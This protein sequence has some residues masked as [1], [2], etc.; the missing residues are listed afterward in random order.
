[1]NPIYGAPGA[2]LKYAPYGAV[3]QNKGR[4]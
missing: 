4:I 3:K 1:M 2:V